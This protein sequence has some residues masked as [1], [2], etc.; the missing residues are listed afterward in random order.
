ML[1]WIVW[2]SYD[3]GLKTISAGNFINENYVQL[4]P[5][6]LDH[7]VIFTVTHQVQVNEILER[8]AFCYWHKAT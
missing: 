4:P 8:N 6:K 5:S 7:I 2:L 3:R 1:G